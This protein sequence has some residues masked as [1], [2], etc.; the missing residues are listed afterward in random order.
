MMKRTILF[1]VPLLAL[2]VACDVQQGKY[3][4]GVELPVV[5]L[6]DADG[7]AIELEKLRG[8][9]VL[10]DLWASWCTPCRKQH[11]RLVKLYD[12][13][14]NAQFE[15]AEGFVIYQVSLDSKKEAWQEAIAKDGLVWP[16]HV[17]ELKG[18]ESSVVGLYEIEAIPTSFLLDQNGMII[19]KD[20]S[21]VELEKVLDNRLKQ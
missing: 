4:N 9:I 10:V 16:N 13:Y 2:F 8:N 6:P 20:L 7:N 3:I 19:G 17:S 5:S 21:M 1:L 15:G 14:K 18:W 11:P 12:K